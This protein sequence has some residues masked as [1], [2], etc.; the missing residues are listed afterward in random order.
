MLKINLSSEIG[1][2]Y[3]NYSGAVIEGSNITCYKQST[4]DLELSLFPERS[5]SAFLNLLKV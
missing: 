5:P 1:D 3:L 2:K 4:I